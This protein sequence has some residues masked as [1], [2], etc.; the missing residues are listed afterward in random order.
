[1]VEAS[2]DY[3]KVGQGLLIAFS[4]CTALVVGVH[5]V[6]LMIST[7]ML[8]NIEAVASLNT[9]EAVNESPHMRLR[10]YVDIAWLLSTF[11]GKNFYEISIYCIYSIYSIQY[12]LYTQ[13]M[14]LG[15]IYCR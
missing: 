10:I 7:C 11:I 15:S 3:A 14:Y 1:M 8:P 6:A 4:I 2:V 5:L 9:I 13:Y 12:T